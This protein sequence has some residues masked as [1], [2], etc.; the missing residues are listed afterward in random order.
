VTDELPPTQATAL[1]QR[2]AS[3][4]EQTELAW[5]FTREHLEQL[6]AKLPSIGAS[7]FVPGVLRNFSDDARAAELEDFAR[8]NLPPEASYSTAKAADEIRFKAALKKRLLPPLDTWIGKQA[9]LA[10][11]AAR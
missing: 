9:K 1:V 8:R 10:R 4:G 7:H 6:L 2:V 11:P 5:K 3:Q